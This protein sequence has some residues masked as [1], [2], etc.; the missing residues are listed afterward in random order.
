[1]K[2]T[3]C[4]PSCWRLLFFC[5]FPAIALGQSNVLDYDGTND[6][7]LAPGGDGSAFDFGTSDFTIEVWIK[8]TATGISQGLVTSRFTDVN[9]GDRYIFYIDTGDKVGFFISLGNNN[10]DVG[11]ILST[12]DV[13]DGTWHHVA[14][15]RKDI[16]TIELYVNGYME[17]SATISGSTATGV[18]I[19]QGV[20]I[21]SGYYPT[22]SSPSDYFTGQMDELRFWSK[23][24]T[25]TEMR[26]QDD[27]ELTGS[28]TDLAAYY[29][30]NQGVAGGNNTSITEVT[31]QTA[32]VDATIY[33]FSLTG[34]TANFVAET[35]RPTT[36]AVIGSV[37][38]RSVSV[39]QLLTDLDASAIAMLITSFGDDKAPD[40]TGPPASLAVLRNLLDADG[41]GQVAVIHW[42]TLEEQGTVGFFIDRR[43]PGSEEWIRVNR[44][45]L[46]GLIDAPLGGEYFYA[47]PG[48]LP[49]IGYYYRLTEQEAWGSTREYAPYQLRY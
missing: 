7:L 26:A 20:T 5:L 25:L 36:V 2:K 48:A 19:N 30:F 23:A 17:D 22:P 9:E 49:G 4:R 32:S 35:P 43:E 40:E 27:I 16:R 34:S 33:N 31:G 47:D 3:S 11:S 14:A 13:A 28:E 44:K 39:D 10:N 46:P 41:D 6:Y 1:M 38:I 15:V 8:S 21:G 24:K 45:L 29:N 12:T 37:D 42:T 18:D